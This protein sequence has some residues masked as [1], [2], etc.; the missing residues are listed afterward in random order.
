MWDETWDFVLILDL[1]LSFDFKWKSPVRRTHDR[2]IMRGARIVFGVS[3]RPANNFLYLR[4]SKELQCL[5]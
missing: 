2:G 5:H 4:K 1:I 3:L